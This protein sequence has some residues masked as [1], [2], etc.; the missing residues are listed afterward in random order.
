MI[1]YKRVKEMAHISNVNTKHS[2][3][4]LSREIK[5]STDVTMSNDK[6]LFINF[7]Q[8]VLSTRGMEHKRNLHV[9]LRFTFTKSTIKFVNRSC[10][11]MVN[12][13]NNFVIRYFHL[14]KH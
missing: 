14:L 12:I 5:S 4:Y 3:I 10:E 9:E 1:Y 6:K 7:H 11:E 2:H 8:I 13:V